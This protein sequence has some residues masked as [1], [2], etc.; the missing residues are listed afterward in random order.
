LTRRILK[1]LEDDIVGR[2]DIGPEAKD[3]LKKGKEMIEEMKYFRISKNVEK[4]GS[5]GG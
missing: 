5:T 3:Y 2:Y 4:V 1:P